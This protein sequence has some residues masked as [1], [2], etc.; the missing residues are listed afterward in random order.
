MQ[1]NFFHLGGTSLNAMQCVNIVNNELG[2]D[3]PLA[4]LFENPTVRA[5]S[6]F[7]RANLSARTLPASPCVALRPRSTDRRSGPSLFFVHPLG[8]LP[9][10]F[11][12]VACL[13]EKVCPVYGLQSPGVAHDP[14][15]VLWAVDSV[16]DVAAKYLEA[17]RATEL[18]GPYHICGLCFGAVVAFEIARQ[19]RESGQEV[20][21]L[22]LIDPHFTN[23]PMDKS[24]VYEIDF[25]AADAPDGATLL[26]D[27]F[28]HGRPSLLPKGTAEERLTWVVQ[29][30]KQRH[31][32]PETATLS[33]A[34]RVVAV[35]RAQANAKNRYIPPK[36][37]GRM[38]VFS[39]TPEKPQLLDLYRFAEH[40]E[41]CVVP[42]NVILKGSGAEVIADWYRRHLR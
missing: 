26:M 1:D 24:S 42:A 41:I 28:F 34:K 31:L 4:A 13:L 16:E 35:L 38:V 29:N 40:V 30:A 14:G 12:Q 7:V 21:S 11:M 27:S 9:F 36:Y 5:F 37:P 17:M 22:A 8:G 32:I 23:L 18:S 25:E 33:W 6:R 15:A 10:G 39:P 3:V 2:T 19:L 20:G